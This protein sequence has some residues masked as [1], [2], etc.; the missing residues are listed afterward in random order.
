VGLEEIVVSLKTLGIAYTV[1]ESGADG[2]V[3]MLPDYGRVLGLWPHWRGENALWV[4]PEFFQQLRIGA[5]DDGWMNPGGDRIWIAPEEEFFPNGQE[6]PPVID[7]G[8]FVLVAEKTGCRLESRGEARAW[9]TGARV[10]FRIT[11]R[12]RPLDD[13]RLAAMW[14]KTWLRQAGYEEETTLELE[15]GCACPVWLWNITQVRAGAEVRVPLRRYWGDTALSK[16]PSGSVGVA[17]NCAVVSFKGN[18]GVRIG[19]NAAD[20]GSRIIC[21]EDR[22]PGRAQM[23]VKDFSREGRGD[24]GAAPD[25]GRQERPVDCR[26]KSQDGFGEFSCSSPPILP[27]GKRRIQWKTSLCSFSGRTDAIGAFGERISS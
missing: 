2:G 11:R 17:D 14:G 7:P 26:W 21:R 18:Y 23:L 10:A 8:H 19:V 13:A 27:N 25:E 5:K 6:V 15:G 4:N 9:K 12:V 3:L 16:L 1:L 20:A 24:S 22:E